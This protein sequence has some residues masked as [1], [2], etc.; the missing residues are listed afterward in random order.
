MPAPKTRK[1]GPA[2]EAAER[3]LAPLPKELREGL[4][5]ATVRELAR[6]LDDPGNSLTS[7]SAASAQVLALVNR[8]RELTPAEEEA[9]AV[10]DIQRRASLQLAR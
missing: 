4:L 10:T 2:A 7:K 5:A 3:E 8:L 9:D 1:L 6:Q